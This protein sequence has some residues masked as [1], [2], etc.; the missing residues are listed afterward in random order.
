LG[1]ALLGRSFE[2]LPG[3]ITYENSIATYITTPLGMSDTVFVPQSGSQAS[4][5]A[6]GYENGGPVV[7]YDLQWL[8]PW[9]GLY[10][11]LSDLTTLLMSMNNVDGNGDP[12]ATKILSTQS[13]R[14]LELPL[15]MSP[16]SKTAQGTPFQMIYLKNKLAR[17]LGDIVPGYSSHMI[18]IPE[19][20]LGFVALSN[21][22]VDMSQFT[23]PAAV[24]MIPLVEQL[25]RANAPLP[26]P[27]VE[28][29][30]FQGL[31][32]GVNAEGDAGTLTI[33]ASSTGVLQAADSR[34]SPTVY[35]LLDSLGRTT[36][37][38]QKF[39]VTWAGNPFYLSCLE[40]SD[41]GA[42]GDFFTFS[43]LNNGVYDSLLFQ[44]SLYIRIG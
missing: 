38:T 22:E 40:I 11:T 7:N 41:S 9:G 30:E 34:Y 35:Y 18:H 13:M 24:A 14:E 10:S 17:T 12:G 8:R 29:L 2:T 1:F 15:Y 31:F 21:A 44:G 26:S 43:R 28:P 36:G 6:I 32:S 16:D 3:H 4:R 20:K 25:L 33:T 5:V 27:P 19:L 42:E 23:T 39:Q 37:G